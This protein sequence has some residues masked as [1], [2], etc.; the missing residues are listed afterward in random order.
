MLMNKVIVFT[1]GSS[2][3]NPGRGGWGAVIASPKNVYELTGRADTT[4]NNRMELQAVIE[5]LEFLQKNNQA[6][7]EIV[8]NSDSQYFKN[9]FEKWM[10]GWQ[11]RGWLTSTKQPVLNQDQWE[12][13]LN[14][15]PLFPK[16][17]INHVRGH[18]GIPGNE[19]ADELATLSA[20]DLAPLCYQGSRQNY[21]VDLSVVSSAGTNSTKSKSKK[22][23]K[24]MCYLSMVDGVIKEHETWAECQ[25]RTDGQSKARYRR[26]DSV[27][28]RDEIVRSWRQ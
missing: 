19:R 10:Y 23:G 24:A 27:A 5:S 12:K 11:S 4:T 1:D 17:S 28:E 22:T 7:T 21:T 2:R 6:Q 20:D 25:A 26:A 9:G 14:L 15:K 18:V 8:I 16:L 13:L 3:G